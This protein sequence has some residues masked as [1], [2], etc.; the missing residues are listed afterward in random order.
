MAIVNVLS[1]VHIKYNHE[2]LLIQVSKLQLILE[3]SGSN[4]RPTI[5]ASQ[6]GAAQEERS[7][8]PSSIVVL[9][10]S[11]SE[12]TEHAITPTSPA[13]PLIST[14]GT[15]LQDE[16]LGGA[17]SMALLDPCVTLMDEVSLPNTRSHVYIDLLRPSS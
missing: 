14:M 9:T 6:E 2:G 17:E 16:L 7:S 4:D 3:R 1:F 15:S 8:R 12:D 11:N 10:R 5:V 13:P